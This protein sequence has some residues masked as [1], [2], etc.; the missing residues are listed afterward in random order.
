MNYILYNPLSDNFKGEEHLKALIDEVS[1]NFPE[2]VMKDVT[3][4][5]VDA[6]IAEVT[7]EDNVILCGGDGTLNHFINSVYNKGVKANL[8]YKYGGTGNDF[9]RDIDPELKGDLIPLNKY[10]EH[11]PLVTIDGKHQLRFINGIGFGIDGMACKV[12]DDQKAA[13]A[14]EIN[15]TSISINLLLFHYKC[16]SGTITVDGE[17]RHYKKIWLA[18]AMQGRYYGGGM[19]A[20]PYQDRLSGKMTSCVWHDVGRIRALMN[21]PSI[22]KG[23]HVNKK[24][25]CEMREGKVIEVHFESPMDLQVDGET[26]RDV[27]DYRVE[28]TD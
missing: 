28:F 23:S 22:F 8:Y 16:P 21:F 27:T 15:Y 12:G 26:Y 19:I 3:Q 2:P 6:L 13:G 7:E 4:L 24:K 17:S 5:D 1:E 20:A 25:L 10:I 9:A 11:L 18:S 14:K